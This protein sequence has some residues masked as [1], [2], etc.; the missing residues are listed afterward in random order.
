MCNSGKLF[1]NTKPV[2]G[3][4]HGSCFSTVKICLFLNIHWN[5]N[6]RKSAENQLWHLIVKTST[7]ERKLIDCLPPSHQ[8]S[9][10]RVFS[11]TQSLSAVAV[12]VWLG[13]YHP[14]TPHSYRHD[15]TDPFLGS[16]CTVR[17]ATPHSGGG[18]GGEKPVASRKLPLS[19]PP[20]FLSSIL[21][22][23][24]WVTKNLLFK[25]IDN[26]AVNATNL[27]QSEIAA[28][29]ENTARCLVDFVMLL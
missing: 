21:L 9:P 18:G 10:T 19:T 17:P 3:R 27:G 28:L 6:K 13:A 20:C 14:E 24:P 25:P 22:A 11:T 15:F 1:L 26:P 4:H 5:V 16:T 2:V 29:K 12:P 8:P 7:K 23:P